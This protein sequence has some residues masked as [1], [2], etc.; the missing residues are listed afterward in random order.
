MKFIIL[1]I[2]HMISLYFCYKIIR[3]NMKQINI[4]KESLVIQLVYI[5]VTLILYGG[6]PIYE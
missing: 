6:I 2:Q 3:T 4:A 5:F 1:C